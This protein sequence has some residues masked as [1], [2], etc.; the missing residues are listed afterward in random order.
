MNAILT[1]DHLFIVRGGDAEKRLAWLKEALSADEV[2][3]YLGPGLLRLDGAEPPVPDTP[4]AVAAALNTKAPAPS[5][6]RTNMWSV[7][8]FIEQR[9]HR[10]TLQ[11]WMAE[12]FAAPVVPTGFHKWLATLPL[13]LIVDSWYD[14]AMRAALAETGRTDAV[15]IQGVSR[16]GETRDIWTKTYDPAGGEL[17][18]GSTARTILYTPHGGVRPAANFLVADS[19][20][21]EVLTEIDIQTPIPDVV[22]ERR[23]SRGFLFIGCRFDDQMLRTYARQIIKRSKGPHFAVLDAATLTKNERCFLASSGITVIDLAAEEAVARLI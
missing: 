7:A 21:V 5:K 20:Y 18:A 13:S 4:E 2:V 10:R 14:G 3:P 1:S 17:E 22:K 12:I 9:R 16:A 8:Q 23:T 11:A 15:E 6:I 19:D